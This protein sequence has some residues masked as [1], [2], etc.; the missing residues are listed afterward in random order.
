M[1]GRATALEFPGGEG[2]QPVGKPRQSASWNSKQLVGSQLGECPAQVL[3]RVT[4]GLAG[5][6]RAVEARCVCLLVEGGVKE[7]KETRG[8]SGGGGEEGEIYGLIETLQ[9]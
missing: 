7:G 8:H 5:T 3:Q 9:G 2:R 6:G 4:G 1:K